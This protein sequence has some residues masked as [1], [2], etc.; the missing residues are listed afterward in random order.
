MIFQ[1][2]LNTFQ[3]QEQSDPAILNTV[4]KMMPSHTKVFDFFR[5]QQVRW[6]N[7]KNWAKFLLRFFLLFKNSKI[8]P[9]PSSLGNDL[10][11]QVEVEQS[12]LPSTFS[13]DDASHQVLMS[14]HISRSSIRSL[15]S[16]EGNTEDIHDVNMKCYGVYRAI[17]EKFQGRGTFHKHFIKIS[18]TLVS[19]E[20]TD[21]LLALKLLQ[22]TQRIL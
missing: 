7:K 14:E 21:Q 10:A 8:K 4:M 19:F 12:P 1:N 3:L 15:L 11:V 16:S 17:P 22:D 2:I 5:R 6:K 13:L 9:E 18:I 20:I